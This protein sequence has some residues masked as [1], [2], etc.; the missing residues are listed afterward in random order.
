VLC[1]FRPAE[2]FL[3]TASNVHG[4]RVF[5]LF[6]FCFRFACRHPVILTCVQVGAW[7]SWR[8]WLRAISRAAKIRQ[9]R[10]NVSLTAS[11][12]RRKWKVSLMSS[13]PRTSPK[14]WVICKYK[15]FYFVI[16]SVSITKH[17]IDWY[18]AGR[19]QSALTW[20]VC[21]NLLGKVNAY[22]ILQL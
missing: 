6:M 8:Q 22:Y 10:W 17:N 12:K 2:N 7:P 4:V 21:L 15:M 1:S 14:D 16:N 19:A 3:K 18:Y 20:A 13:S 9:S 5:V 11:S